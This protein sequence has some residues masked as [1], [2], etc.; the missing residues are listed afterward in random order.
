MFGSDFWQFLT[1]SRK[2]EVVIYQGKHF[3][4]FSDVSCVSN[5]NNR[6]SEDKKCKIIP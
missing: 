2:L 4:E 1:F 3:L 6:P 5:W